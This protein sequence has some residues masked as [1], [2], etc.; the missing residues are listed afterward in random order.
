LKSSASPVVP[1]GNCDAEEEPD[2]QVAE[3]P[4]TQGL[5]CASSCYHLKNGAC[6]AAEQKGVGVL[7]DRSWLLLLLL[8]HIYYYLNEFLLL[9]LEVN[10]TVGLLKKLSRHSL[11]TGEFTSSI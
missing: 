6:C 3:W 2:A 5:H 4:G 9:F 8:C 1:V 10:L 7:G 11:V